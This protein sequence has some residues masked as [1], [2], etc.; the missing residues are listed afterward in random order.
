MFAQHEGQE[1]VKPVGGVFG[2]I[3]FLVVGHVFLVLAQQLSTQV[4]QHDPNL[5]MFRH[6]YITLLCLHFTSLSITIKLNQLPIKL[7]I[8]IFT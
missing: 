8:E 1:S 7:T 5:G 6:A 3:D 4:G 2:V